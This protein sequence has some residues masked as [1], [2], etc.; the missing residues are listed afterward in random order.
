MVLEIKDL[1]A[2]LHELGHKVEVQDERPTFYTGSSGFIST[3]EKVLLEHKLS[4]KLTFFK[5][6]SLQDSFNNLSEA[7]KI[8]ERLDVI[9]REGLYSKDVMDIASYI[10][11]LG[12]IN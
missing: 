1:I 8:A 6:D 2:K 10:D 4:K 5:G 7:L 11:G 3:N 9:N 12:P